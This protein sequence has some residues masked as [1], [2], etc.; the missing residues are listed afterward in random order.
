MMTASLTLWYY[1][2]KEDA[3]TAKV[4]EIGSDSRLSFVRFIM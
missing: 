3:S 1:T 4:V 2:L